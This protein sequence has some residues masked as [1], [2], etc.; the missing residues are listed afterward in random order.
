M[1]MTVFFFPVVAGPSRKAHP[2]G[3]GQKPVPP[4]DFPDT[5]AEVSFAPNAVGV[6]F[7]SAKQYV[8]DIF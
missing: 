3:C 5:N 6:Y 2:G 1:L 8:H 7:I 4:N